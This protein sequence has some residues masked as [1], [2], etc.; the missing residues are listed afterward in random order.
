MFPCQGTFRS[1]LPHVRSFPALR[2]LP[3]SPTSI[4][5]FAFLWMCLGLAYPKLSPRDHVGSPRFLGASISAVPCKRP[6]RVLLHS[7]PFTNAYL[8]PSRS[9][10]LSAPGCCCYEAQ[11]LHL[12]YGPDIALSTLNSYRYL[13]EPKTRF[14]VRR[15]FLLPGWELHPLK[16]PGFAWR[17]E[18]ASHVHRFRRHENFYRRR[19]TQHA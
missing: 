7:S 19:K 14:L 3:T 17:T 10:T 15:L 9:S 18:A 5:A 13:H 4:T 16:A 11:S 2:V 1:S 12:R 6:R 8:L